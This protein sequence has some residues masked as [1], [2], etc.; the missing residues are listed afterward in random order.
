MAA[1]QSSRY[2]TVGG[3]RMDFAA[4]SLC[5]QALAAARGW[6]V[7]SEGQAVTV[8]S[9]D[10]CLRLRTSGS[11]VLLEITHGPVDGAPVGW[12]DLYS[13]PPPDAPELAECIEYGLD[14]MQPALGEAPSRR[15]RAAPDRRA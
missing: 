8:R 12:L 7:T 9:G 15:T 10:A 2:P 13:G 14:L 3:R 6:V 5:F 11:G 1:V 4:A